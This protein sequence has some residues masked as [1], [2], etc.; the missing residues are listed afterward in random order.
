[1][2][3]KNDVSGVTHTCVFKFNS[4]TQRVEYEHKEN[5]DD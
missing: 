3:K 1:M 2:I 5:N 4:M